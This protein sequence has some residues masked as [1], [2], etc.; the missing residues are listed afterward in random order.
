MTVILLTQEANSPGD[1][2]AAE[3]ATCLGLELVRQEQIEQRVAERMGVDKQSVRRLLQG[4]ASLVEAWTIGPNRL[5]RYLAVEVV[6]LAARG[7]IVIQT[8]KATNPLRVIG[9]VVCVHV[10]AARRPALTRTSGTAVPDRRSPRSCAGLRSWLLAGG[11][12]DFEH[13]DLALNTERIPL[14]ECVEQVRRLAQGSHFQPTA[15]S[16]AML[17]SSREGSLRGL[18]ACP[19]FGCRLRSTGPGSRCRRRYHQIADSAL[20]RRSHSSRRTAPAR[21]KRLRRLCRSRTVACIPAGGSVGFLAGA[22]FP[23]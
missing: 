11:W 22:M 23:P 6:K 4:N 21:Q 19:R 7:N 3:L 9:H 15:A 16:R 13:Y 1:Q 8:W 20:Q 18:P 14:D 5:V 2:V 17:A 10:C 12:D